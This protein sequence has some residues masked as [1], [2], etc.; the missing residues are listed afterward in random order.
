[1]DERVIKGQLCRRRLCTIKDPISGEVMVNHT[2]G[3][4]HYE[5]VNAQ[6]EC[7]LDEDEQK[8]RSRR[9]QGRG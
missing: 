1:M 2:N 3:R 5:W 8:H 6:G 7:L 9:R 4:Y